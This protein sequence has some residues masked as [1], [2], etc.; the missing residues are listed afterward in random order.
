MSRTPDIIAADIAAA[1]SRANGL[2]KQFVAA[3]REIGEL[4]AEAEKTIA[5]SDW[6]KWLQQDAYINQRLAQHYIAATKEKPFEA[7]QRAIRGALNIYLSDEVVIP[8]EH[9]LV[10]ATD[11]WMSRLFIWPAKDGAGFWA[12]AFDKAR[13]KYNGNRQPI[14]KEHLAEIIA[15][16]M[17][18]LFEIANAAY[19]TMPATPKD[20]AALDDMR[21]RHLDKFEEVEA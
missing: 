1:R 6:D 17:R 5:P 8:D 2:C 4:L 11:V 14:P 20:I 10:R 19:E 18:D 12:M 7:E 3:L 9:H 21:V 15:T 13:N 16:Y